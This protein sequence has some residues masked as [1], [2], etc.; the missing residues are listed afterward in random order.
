MKRITVFCGS[1]MGNNPIYGEIAFQLG[2]Q[3]AKENLGLVYGGAKVGLMGKVADGVLSL[4]GEVIGVIP[5]FL[6]TKE[7]AYA[8]LE[9]LR[10]VKSMHER[11]SLMNDLCDGVIALP[12]GFGTLEELFEMLTWAQLGLHEKPIALLNV[13]GYYNALITLLN[14]MV[15]EGLLRELNKDMVLVGKDVSTV[16]NLMRNY[17]APKVK[18]WITNEQT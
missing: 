9:D 2:V 15:K 10:T 11:K 13:N 12:G 14:N 1:S 6:K 4:N 7:V 16:L 3:M 8:E 5:E 18:K 17:K